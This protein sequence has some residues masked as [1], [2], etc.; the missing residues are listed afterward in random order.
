MLNS[1]TNGFISSFFK[2]NARH[3]V[4]RGKKAGKEDQRDAGGLQTSSG[5]K[6]GIL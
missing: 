4:A 1:A 5:E 3:N 6:T 2:L